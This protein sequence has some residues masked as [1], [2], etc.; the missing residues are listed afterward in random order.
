MTLTDAERDLLHESV[1]GGRGPWL[2]KYAAFVAGAAASIAIAKLVVEPRFDRDAA[3][4]VVLGGVVGA[5]VVGALLVVVA[6]I[7]YRNVRLAQLHAI[8]GL[9]AA[10][11]DAMLAQ[12]Y[13][14]AALI[15]RAQIDGDREAACAAARA[16]PKVTSATA[17]G[18]A[19][20]V[21]TVE[22]ETTDNVGGIGAR[23]FYTNYRPYAA[24]LAIAAALPSARSFEARLD[25]ERARPDQDAGPFG[26][27]K[28]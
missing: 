11:A 13:R 10:A 1:S 2:A 20:V 14:G 5:L 7:A 16:V 17:D 21:T 15:V 27:L 9:D 3:K 25:G 12:R 24:L 23:S 18:D 28:R 26:T 22:L 8:R 4:L 6:G 19:I